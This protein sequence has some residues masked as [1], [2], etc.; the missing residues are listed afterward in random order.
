M[1]QQCRAQW[2]NDAVHSGVPVP[3]TGKW[4]VE[5]SLID[6]L[7]PADDSADRS[8]KVIITYHDTTIT[9]LDTCKQASFRYKCHV[10][11]LVS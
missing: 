6:C 1:D 2:V 3:Y 8:I 9:V 11:R 4:L 5:D 7:G 10:P